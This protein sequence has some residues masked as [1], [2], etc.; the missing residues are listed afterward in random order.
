[1]KKAARYTTTGII[2]ASAIFII[3]AVNT[4]V[5]AK[6]AIEQACGEIKTGMSSNEITQVANKYNVQ[7][8]EQETDAKLTRGAFM[9]T[10]TCRVSLENGVVSK[11]GGVLRVSHD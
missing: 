11:V 4:N 9:E 2:L 3:F 10:L 8:T 5:S 1:M 7:Y 6:N